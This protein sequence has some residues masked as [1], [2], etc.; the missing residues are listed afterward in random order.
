[1]F[2]AHKYNK[3]FSERYHKPEVS[4]AQVGYHTTM[5]SWCN[6]A[7]ETNWEQNNLPQMDTKCN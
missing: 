2:S 1:V 5:D 4:S 6:K 3:N 7:T